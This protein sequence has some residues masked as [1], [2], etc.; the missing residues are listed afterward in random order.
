MLP[1]WGIKIVSVDKQD[2]FAYHDK[3]IISSFFNKFESDSE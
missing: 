3:Y 1:Q 2:I